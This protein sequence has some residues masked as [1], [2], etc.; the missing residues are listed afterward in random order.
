MKDL[1]SQ[2][3]SVVASGNCSGCGLCAQISPFV[4]MRMNTS[5]YLRPVW[6]GGLVD[7]STEQ[8][9]V[10]FAGACPGRRV[11][12]RASDE[13]VR[14][15]YLGPVVDA[16]EAWAA[17]PEIRHKASSGG[18]LTALISFLVGTGEYRSAT[19]ATSAADPRRTVSVKITTKEE[20]LGAA[21]SRYAPVAAAGCCELGGGPDTAVVGKPCEVSAVRQ[22]LE[23][24]GQE[25]KPLLLSFFCAGTPSQLATDELLEDL[26]LGA[27]EQLAELRYRGHG[28][29]GDFYAKSVD[30]KTATTGYDDSWGRRLGPTTQWRCKICPDGVGES[31]DIT[32]GD[33]WH[34]DENGYPEFS[35][36]HGVSV[37]IA[38]TE[39]GR[40]VIQRA[41][42][43][44][45]IVG[46][47]INLDDV[48]RVQP[49]Q[50]KR[51]I[52][53][54]GRLTGTVIAFN[55]VPR[56]SGFGLV[57]SARIAPTAAIRAIP[58]TFLRA[59]RLR[60]SQQGSR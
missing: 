40:D 8:Q 60:R 30:G 6:E 11:V 15:R 18:T 52:T 41:L 43:E 57:R 28:W 49:L 2:I 23:V 58:G 53:L 47:R 38:R 59:R 32:A 21:G 35:D 26:G 54:A 22:L 34:S 9:L 33:F 16:W 7:A 24:R 42:E 25:H 4:R 17:D 55:K 50:T 29:P 19:A 44:K 36:K 3:A 13:A 14:H 56:Y 27:S 46:R 5:G 10:E 31:A 20:A 48:S 12:A 1:S 45:I 51:R 37:L 39:R